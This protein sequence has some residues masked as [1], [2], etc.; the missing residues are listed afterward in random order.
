MSGTAGARRTQQVPSLWMG[1]FWMLPVAQTRRHRQAPGC[2]H[3]PGVAGLGPGVSGQSSCGATC[4]TRV[5]LSPGGD[6]T[7]P[8]LRGG[9]GR[10]PRRQCQPRGRARTGGGADDGGGQAGGTGP[11]DRP[12]LAG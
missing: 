1:Q 10:R 2:G 5:A 7:H 6:R 3:L 9:A 4:N 11:R 8:G 12:R